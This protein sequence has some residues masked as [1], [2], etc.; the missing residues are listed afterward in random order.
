MAPP[1]F[2]SYLKHDHSTIV[3]RRRRVAADQG[4]LLATHKAEMHLDAG[5]REGSQ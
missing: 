1:S 4:L 3:F 2:G 5:E